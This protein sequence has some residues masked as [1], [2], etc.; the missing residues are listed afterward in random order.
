MQ[1]QPAGSLLSFLAAVSDPR[2]QHGRQHPLLVILA[3]MPTDK[4]SLTEPGAVPR[5]FSYVVGVPQV[6]W[7]IYAPIPTALVI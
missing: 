6:I 3:W 4:K 5:F 1:A 2:R 7:F